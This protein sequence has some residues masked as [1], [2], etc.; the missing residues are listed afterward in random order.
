M[1]WVPDDVGSVWHQ[2]LVLCF[3]SAAGHEKVTQQTLT[4]TF[5]SSGV[6]TNI[7]NKPALTVSK[8][9]KQ[10]ALNERFF[11]SASAQVT[12]RRFSLPAGDAALSGLQSAAD[13][14]RPGRHREPIMQL[15]GRL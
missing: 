3:P 8:Y 14:F 5:N 6:L 13:R 15:T 7:D 10:K 11:I 4:L 2:H 1:L 12:F 9:Q